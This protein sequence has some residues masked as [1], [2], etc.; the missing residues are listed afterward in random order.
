MP[1][2]LGADWSFAHIDPH[3]L[4]AAGYTNAFRY[5]APLP[6]GKVITPQEYAADKAAGLTV[7]LNF[8]QT[9]TNA[10]GGWGQGQADGFIVL[11]ERKS[12]GAAVGVTI[13][14]ADFDDRAHPGVMDAIDTYLRGAESVSGHAE[15]VYGSIRVIEEMF[16]RNQQRQTW[17]TQAWSGD[18]VSPLADFY[19]RTGHTHFIPGVNNNEYDEDVIIHVPTPGGTQVLDSTTFSP[20]PLI[21]S[22]TEFEHPTLGH[23]AAAVTAAGAVYCSPATAYLGGG[24]HGA[25][26]GAAFYDTGRRAAAIRRPTK[27]ER[28]DGFGYVIVDTAGE[29]YDFFP[30]P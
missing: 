8:E 23:C 26:A 30:K 11:T 20:N 9:A 19:Q 24:N 6:N 3:V 27:A 12:L 25:S 7:H 17:Q 21:V 29:K 10:L 14:S 13:Y 28:A 4:I 16:R 18:V 5:L 15:G 2:V 22:L 1:E